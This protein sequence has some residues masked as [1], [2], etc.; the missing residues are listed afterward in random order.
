MSDKQN[1][2]SSRGFAN[3]STL[4]TR[5]Y[6]RS[7]ARHSSLFTRHYFFSFAAL[8]ACL[9]AAS[10]ARGDG[11]RKPT[12]EAIGSE[13]QCPCG[14]VAPLN[15]CPMLDCAEKAEMRAFIK[16]EI[17]DGK[18]ETAI[19]QDI[20]IRYGV[21]ALTAPPAKGFNLAV[22]ILPGIGLMVGLG[23]VIVIVR[24]WKGKPAMVPVPPSATHDPKVLT[25]VEEEMKSAGLG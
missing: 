21:Q 19:L 18:D 6:F 23:I 15:Q 7:F 12:L 24:R 3:Y 1:N 4:A 11:A 10:V 8:A 5:R 25:A 14:C 17:A 22:W 13:V 9:L 20:S 2:P 16:K